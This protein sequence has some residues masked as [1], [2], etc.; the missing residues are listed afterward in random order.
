MPSK[1]LVGS[2]ATLLGLLFVASRASALPESTRS[3]FYVQGVV[4]SFALQTDSRSTG[5]YHADVEFGW[6]TTM[7]HDGFVIGIRQGFDVA[8]C[9]LGETVL[10]AGYDIA[11]PIH[12][13]RFELTVA[14][15]GVVGFDYAFP[16]GFGVGVIT[17]PRLGVGVDVKFFFYKGLYLL[18]RPFE[19]DL[20]DYAA[21]PF[22]YAPA[23]F[24]FSAGLGLGFAF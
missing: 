19:T 1:T 8:D 4:A 12:Y 24:Y 22:P 16:C 2:A 17:G 15:Y 21:S 9:S 23:R 13:G 7:R 5:F 11:L 20:A 3:P 14:P 10:R 18:G 6:H